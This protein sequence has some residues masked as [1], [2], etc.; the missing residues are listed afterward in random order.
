MKVKRK[1]CVICNELFIPQY[2]SLQKACSPLHA[3]QYSKLKLASNKVQLNKL[4]NSKV[5]LEDLETLK[6]KTQDVVN[7]YIRIRDKG[8]ECISCGHPLDKFFDAG[9]IFDK[10]QYSMIRFDLDCLAG[11][12]IQCNRFKEGEYDKARLRQAN[13][14]GVERYQKLESRSKIALRVPY[15][16][17]R[18]ELRQIQKEVKALIKNNI[19]L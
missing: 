9:H 19:S 15:T 12:C 7:K 5:K 18:A 4:R 10:K 13:R 6:R 14:I 2:T 11:Q 3:I 17:T 16:W 1:R 8:K